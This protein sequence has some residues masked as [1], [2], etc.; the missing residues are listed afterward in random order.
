MSKKSV[1]Y[2][3][4]AEQKLWAALEFGSLQH[5]MKSHRANSPS[6]S[7]NCPTLV[8]CNTGMTGC[9]TSRISCNCNR[10]TP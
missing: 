5:E 2:S 10:V 7:A 8:Y 3:S 4:E 1:T 9:G 6:F